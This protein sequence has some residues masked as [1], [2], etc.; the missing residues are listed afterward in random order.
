VFLSTICYYNYYYCFE[1]V[2]VYNFYSVQKYPFGKFVEKISF[3]NSPLIRIYQ[4]TR[5]NPVSVQVVTE[6]IFTKGLDRG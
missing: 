6:A 1:L 5:Y 4:E 2:L 3:I